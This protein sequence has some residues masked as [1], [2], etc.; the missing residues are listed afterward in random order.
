MISNTINNFWNDA[1]INIPVTVFC[2]GSVTVFCNG[3]GSIKTVILLKKKEKNGMTDEKR[4]QPTR[5][6]TVGRVSEASFTQSHQPAGFD[7][8]IGQVIPK[9]IKFLRSAGVREIGKYYKID[10][11]RRTIIM[12]FPL[13]KKLVYPVMFHVSFRKHYTPISKVCNQETET[14]HFYSACRALFNYA[15]K[16]GHNL[17]QSM[18]R[19]RSI[20]LICD[21]YTRSVKG[22]IKKSYNGIS[23]AAIVVKK[24]GNIWDGLKQAW[25]WVLNYISARLRALRQALRQKGVKAFGDVAVFEKNLSLIVE[26]ISLIWA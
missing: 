18:I 7:W 21:R 12:G 23:V 10:Y 15:K 1:H 4:F 25:N 16:R 3:S 17:K 5:N 24:F 2:N 19:D 9:Y 26:W 14:G 8:V 11:K 20:F 13:R 6:N 22:V